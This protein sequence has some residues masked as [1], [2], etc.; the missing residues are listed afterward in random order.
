MKSSGHTGWESGANASVRRLQDGSQEVMVPGVFAGRGEG[1]SDIFREIDEDLRKENLAKLWARYGRWVIVAAVLVVVATAVGVGWRQ[2]RQQQSAAQGTQF[3]AA[4]DLVRAGKDKDA[5]DAFAALAQHAGSG[6]A[7]L[8]RMEE[9]ALKART[10]DVAGALAIYDRLAS[11]ASVD[12]VFRDAATVLAARA[13]LDNGD[14]AGAIRRLKP[15]TVDSSPWRPFAVELTGFADLKAGD[16]G[17]ARKSFQELADD[18][19]APAG[20]RQRAAQMIA[21]LTP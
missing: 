18:P 13:A 7:I 8:A 21:T 10:G 5:A 2:Y 12:A 3:A 19:N 4:L 6:H 16:R 20:A 11:D 15:L 1:L 9:A 14:A 17:A